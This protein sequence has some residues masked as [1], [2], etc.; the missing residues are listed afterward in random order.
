MV[1]LISAALAITMLFGAASLPTSGSQ[2]TAT[3]PITVGKQQAIYE[4]YRTITKQEL[5]YFIS[6]VSSMGPG[7]SGKTSGYQ[8]YALD[9]K[10]GVITFSNR[11]SMPN[12]KIGDVFWYEQVRGVYSIQVSDIHDGEFWGSKQYYDKYSQTVTVYDKGSY[13]ADTIAIEN[14]L[15]ADGKHSDGYW[16]VFKN[17]VED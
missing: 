8:N 11:V 16:Y 4:K 10:T 9:R 17:L 7:G 5:N 1:K 13:L 6:Y 2:L 14:S 15:P 12:I 3:V